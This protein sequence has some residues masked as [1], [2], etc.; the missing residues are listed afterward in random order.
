[1]HILGLHLTGCA[2]HGPA[3]NRPVSHDLVFHRVCISHHV[4]LLYLY[5]TVYAPHRPA[6]HK[7]ASR[8]PASEILRLWSAMAARGSCILSSIRWASGAYVD[9]NENISQE[10][11][12]LDTEIVPNRSWPD[13]LQFYEAE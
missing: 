5:L 2:S 10:S 7:P 1:M 3:S 13:A 12:E 8:R 9:R 11:P 6:S 4:H